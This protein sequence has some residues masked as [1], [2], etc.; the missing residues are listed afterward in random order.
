MDL[1]RLIPHLRKRMR[2]RQNLSRRPILD[3]TT[4]I[5]LIVTSLVTLAVAFGVGWLDKRHEE[6]TRRVEMA[7]A[8]IKNI[9]LFGFASIKYFESNNAHQ[10]GLIQSQNSYLTHIETIA[11][12]QGEEIGKASFWV[13]ENNMKDSEVQYSN[14]QDALSQLEVLSTEMTV[15]QTSFYE[16]YDSLINKKIDSVT[17][18]YFD[19]L[20]EKRNINALDYMKLGKNLKSKI[21]HDRYD[22]VLHRVSFEIDSMANQAAY[23]VSTIA[24]QTPSL[25]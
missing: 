5:T 16:F 1:R 22:S 2:P 18:V 8:Y 7:N 4:A 23:K 14:K 20:R 25:F 21:D 6:S 9:K 15:I 13:F 17:N 11:K 10:M 3:L 19:G 12:R 24:P